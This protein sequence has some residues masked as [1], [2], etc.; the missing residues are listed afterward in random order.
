MSLLSIK[1]E[2]DD[3]GKLSFSVGKEEKYKFEV[4]VLP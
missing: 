4:S 2:T 3:L 1:V